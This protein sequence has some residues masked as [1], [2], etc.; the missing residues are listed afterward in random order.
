MRG[1]SSGRV[2]CLGCPYTQFVKHLRRDGFTRM[3]YS[4]Y[5][6]HSPSKENAEKTG[7]K[8]TANLAVGSCFLKKAARP[9][10]PWTIVW[11]GRREGWGLCTAP[12]RSG[13]RVRPDSAVR[14]IACLGL[15]RVT[16]GR[17]FLQSFQAVENYHVFGPL[18][19]TEF[20]VFCKEHAKDAWRFFSNG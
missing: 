18:A 6:R 16:P 20:L 2:K 19:G 4:V 11:A 10:P 9:S 14:L 13:G 15:R 3:Q 7:S 1:M 17:L 12:L 5:A 8:T